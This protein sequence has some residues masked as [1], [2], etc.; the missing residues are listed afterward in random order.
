M[1]LINGFRG[2]ASRR[3]WLSSLFYK[4]RLF[5]AFVQCSL[6]G[7]SLKTRFTT[8]K[9]NF[10]LLTSLAPSLHPL[11][12]LQLTSTS[13]SSAYIFTYPRRYAP[14]LAKKAFRQYCTDGGSVVGTR[15][16]ENSSISIFHRDKEFDYGDVTPPPSL[17][18]NALSRNE[19]PKAAFHPCPSTYLR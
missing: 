9:L 14:L 4:Y 11:P 10:E 16:L 5:E 18:E 12:L 3:I 19:I 2:A 17:R 15:I 7:V 8:I 13:T 1:L 6:I